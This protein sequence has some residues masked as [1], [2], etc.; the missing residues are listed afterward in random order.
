MNHKDLDAW[1]QAME[2]AAMVYEVT[3][4]FPREEIYGLTAQMRRAAVSVAS[5]ISEG[6]ARPG[7]KE[8][9]LF[10][11]YALGS[12]AELETQ[13]LLASRIGYGD[14]AAPIGQVERVRALLLGLRRS[15][16]RNAQ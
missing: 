15:H 9:L 8:F 2:L 7:Q 13:L 6:A 16:Q 14:F 5:N 12:L 11:G 1:K 4:A 10:I 3:K